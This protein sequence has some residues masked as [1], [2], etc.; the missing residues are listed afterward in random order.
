MR[1][2]RLLGERL[3][4][5][6]TARR[7]AKERNHPIAIAIVLQRPR[8]GSHFCAEVHGAQFTTTSSL[9][10]GVRRWRHGRSSLHAVRSMVL[11]CVCTSSELCSAV[12]LKEN[13]TPYMGEVRT[14]V[15]LFN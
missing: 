15:R 7:R 9:S 12:K 13:P 3:A 1:C 4:G 6:P 11:C 5:L 14:K 10:M 2:N 8:A